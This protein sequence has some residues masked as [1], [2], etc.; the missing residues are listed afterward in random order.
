MLENDFKLAAEVFKDKDE[1]QGLTV[2]KSMLPIFRDNKDIAIVKKITAPLKENDV[3]LYRKKGKTDEYIL[4]RLLKITDNG[5]LIRGDNTYYNE[6]NITND[7]IVGVLKG[8]Y[9]NG[10]YYDCQKSFTYKLY[11]VYI[12]LSYPIRHFILRAIRKLK[13]MLGV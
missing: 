6:T 9:R 13:R 5:Y 1:I 7:D 4:H 11:V 2:G 10:K 12:R 3:L 8:F